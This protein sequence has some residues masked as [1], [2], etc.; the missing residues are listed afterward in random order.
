MGAWGMGPFDNDMAADFAGD[1]DE[2]SESDRVVAI[3]EALT[4]AAAA[5]DYLDADA[6]SIAVAAAALVAAQRPSGEPVDSAY[7]PQEPI[8]PLSDDLRA[9][10]GEALTRVLDDDS[11]LAEVWDESGDTEAWTELINRLCKTLAA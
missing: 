7:G 4:E 9:L 2:L 10:A 5:T 6:G 1:L 8:P 3:R 11:E